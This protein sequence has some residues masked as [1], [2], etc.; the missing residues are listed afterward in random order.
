MCLLILK[1]ASLFETYQ[2]L[3][4]FFLWL[5]LG[6]LF[7]LLI[8]SDLII[9]FFAYNCTIAPFSILF[10]RHLSICLIQRCL[11][12]LRELT[13]LISRSFIML[14]YTLLASQRR[15]IYAQPYSLSFQSFLFRLYMLWLRE[16]LLALKDAHIIL[17]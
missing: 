2:R 13:D 11:M 14:L 1:L 12:H 10:F 5:F 8:L 17:I 16:V 9:N 6:F 3:S 4:L 7:L 15:L